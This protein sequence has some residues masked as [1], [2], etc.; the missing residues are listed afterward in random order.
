MDIFLDLHTQS[1]E[2]WEGRK[3]LQVKNPISSQLIDQIRNWNLIFVEGGKLGNLEKNP[4]WEV[5]AL[6]AT[7]PLLPFIVFTESDF[8][9]DSKKDTEESDSDDDQSNK[10]S[11]DSNSD[12]SSS[13]S[14][15]DS[16]STDSES[17][18]SS[19]ESDSSETSSSSSSSDSDHGR[20]RKR[21]RKKLKR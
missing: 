18:S 19:S 15:S 11:T 3:A 1:F 16:S 14:D 2:D 20:S 4:W 13:D 8:H 10:S 12:D 5:H 7:P 6:T 21:R 17:S 9:F